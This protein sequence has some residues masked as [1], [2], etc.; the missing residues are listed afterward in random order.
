MKLNWIEG[1][2]HHKPLSQYV[3][4]VGLIIPIPYAEVSQTNSETT[5]HKAKTTKPST[6]VNRGSISII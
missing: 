1:H 2:E 4:L 5:F 6:T 3:G